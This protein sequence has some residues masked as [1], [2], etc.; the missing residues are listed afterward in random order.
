LTEQLGKRLKRNFTH[1]QWIV[2]TVI[3]RIRFTIKKKGLPK[4]TSS[5]EKEVFPDYIVLIP[6]RET[7]RL[8]IL[9]P[10]RAKIAFVTAGAEGGTA[11]SPA[12]P[13]SS[14]L[15]TR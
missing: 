8:R 5:E 3:I 13:G 10:V 12:P 15:S 2:R 7:G 11:G 6:L 9:C 14:L 1:F 4:A